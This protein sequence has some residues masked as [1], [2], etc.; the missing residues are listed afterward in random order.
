MAHVQTPPSIPSFLSFKGRPCT[1]E[2]FGVRDQ[3][4]RIPSGDRSARLP[5]LKQ[6]TAPNWSEFLLNREKGTDGWS[7][8]FKILKFLIPSQTTGEEKVDHQ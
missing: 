2:A 4:N 8:A 1:C 7:S 3:G 5:L 6:N